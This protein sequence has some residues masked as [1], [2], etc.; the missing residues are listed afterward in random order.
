MVAIKAPITESL[1]PPNSG[2][3]N[4]RSRDDQCTFY[5]IIGRAE[6]CSAELSSPIIRADDIDVLFIL[7]ISFFMQMG[8]LITQLYTH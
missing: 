6:K 7:Y 4:V 1:I 3:M 5:R 8:V 2:R